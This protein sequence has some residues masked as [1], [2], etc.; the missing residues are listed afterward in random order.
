[1]LY[2]NSLLALEAETGTIRW[3]FQMLPRDNFDLDHQDNPI[4]ADVEV[5]GIQRKVV[6]TLGKA[7]ILWALD[8]ETGEHLWNRQLVTY[9]NVYQ[10]IDPKTG[11]H[12]PE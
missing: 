5:R 2:T 6:Y 1:M 7:G 12:Y 3:F 10:D 11:R 4:L 9:Q 8:R